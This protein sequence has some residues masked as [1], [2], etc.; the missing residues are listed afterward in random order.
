M[1]TINQ[2]VTGSWQLF[3]G[4]GEDFLLTYPHQNDDILEFAIQD[5]EVAP[6]VGLKSHTLSSL[7]RE[8]LNRAIVGPGY[9]YL[10]TVDGDNAIVTL[11]K[12]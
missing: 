2:T 12:W 6:A 1:A 4:A 11:T 9:L 7:D 8:A 10:R 5:T 3:V